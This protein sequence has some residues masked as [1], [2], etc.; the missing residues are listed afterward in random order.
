[1]NKKLKKKKKN[2]IEVRFG[3]FCSTWNLR[4]VQAEKL[5]SL[6]EI[7]TLS[8]PAPSFQL[9]IQDRDGRVALPLP[10]IC[11]QAIPL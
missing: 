4:Y 5:P 6:Q 1:M 9:T 3:D 7:T 11:N 2:V 10:L 8:K